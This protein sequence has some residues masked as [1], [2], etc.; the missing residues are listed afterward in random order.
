MKILSVINARF[1]SDRSLY[2]DLSQLTGVQ[3]RLPYGDYHR[4]DGLVS[5]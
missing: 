4:K 3:L 1:P 5:Y 2:A